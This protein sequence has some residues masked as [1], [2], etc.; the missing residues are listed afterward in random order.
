[1]NIVI[2][3][4]NTTGFYS[5]ELPEGTYSIVSGS[6]F[7]ITSNYPTVSIITG[8]TGYFDTIQFNSM[9]GGDT[10]TIRAGTVYGING[11]FTNLVFTGSNGN[12]VDLTGINNWLSNIT[13]GTAWIANE[14]V[15][16]GYFNSIV[17]TTGSF[18]SITGNG[19]YGTIITGGTGYFNTVTGTG[20]FTRLSFTYASGTNAWINEL[21][22]VTRAF[23]NLLANSSTL[24]NVTGGTGYFSNLSTASLTVGSGYLPSLVFVCFWWNLLYI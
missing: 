7:E 8:G 10:S 19:I 3:G 24:L 22:G 9:T 5:G 15:G 14:V 6:S 2:D 17:G 1:M 12:F 23:S 16:T 21:T 11:V 20:T 13:S 18:N 4:I